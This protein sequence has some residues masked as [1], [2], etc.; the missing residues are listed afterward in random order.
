MDPFLNIYFAGLLLL[1]AFEQRKRLRRFVRGY[2]NMSQHSKIYLGGLL[3]WVVLIDLSS[4]AQQQLPLLVILPWWVLTLGSDFLIKIASIPWL[5]AGSSFP[6]FGGVFLETILAATLVYYCN[7]KTHYVSVALLLFGIAFNLRI[8]YRII[9]AA[10]SPSQAQECTI[11]WGWANELRAFGLLGYSIYSS[12]LLAVIAATCCITLAFS[13][14][15]LFAP[16][17][18]KLPLLLKRKQ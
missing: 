7:Y 2:E 10:G 17:S 6:L 9:A 8:L 13:F 11:C 16:N 3:A 5:F 14:Y 18:F 12:L 15:C 4:F 1:I